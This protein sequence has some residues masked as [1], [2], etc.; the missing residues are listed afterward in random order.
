[1][2]QNIIYRYNGP[3]EIKGIEGENSKSKFTVVMVKLV[4]LRNMYK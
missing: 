3:C 2:N 1:M 4:N